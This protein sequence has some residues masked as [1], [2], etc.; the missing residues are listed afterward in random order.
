MSG[1]RREE[2]RCTNRGW[3]EKKHQEVDASKGN[4]SPRKK[5]HA[6]KKQ[7]EEERL[8]RKVGEADAVVDKT[9]RFGER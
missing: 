6:N 3:L 2:K 1:G 5:W 8:R 4:F 9:E 7:K